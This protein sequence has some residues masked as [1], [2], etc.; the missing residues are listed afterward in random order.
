MTKRTFFLTA[1][2]VLSC[3][4]GMKAT[5][6]IKQPAS[7]PA[8][9]APLFAWSL[10]YAFGNSAISGLSWSGNYLYIA[11]GSYTVYSSNGYGFLTPST[12]V[13]C[14]AED[15]ANNYVQVWPTGTSNVTSFYHF[16]NF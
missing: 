10:V 4:F 14:N 8:V 12:P 7:V 2:I 6:S 5:S 11:S 1:A 3:S 13:Y 15:N 9:Q 16:Q